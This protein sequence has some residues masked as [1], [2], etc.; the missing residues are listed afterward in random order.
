MSREAQLIKESWAAVE[1]QAERAAQ[2][3]YAHIF[4]GH[5]EIRAMFPVMMDVQRERLLQALVRIVQGF[6]NPELLGPYL[7][8]LGRDHRKFAVAPAHYGV[9]GNSLIATLAKYGREAWTPEVEAA[10]RHAYQIAAQ[11]MIDGAQRIAADDPAWWNGQVVTP[12]P[13]APDIPAHTLRADP[14]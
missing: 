13:P 1:P 4:Y 9:V 5:P 8:Q 14:P 12:E 6:E 10:W 3:F 2:Y 11:A 7:H